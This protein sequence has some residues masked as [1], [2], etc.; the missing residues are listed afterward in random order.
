MKVK[1]LIILALIF[2]LSIPWSA[3][4]ISIKPS[5][6]WDDT[7]DVIP[8]PV[9]VGFDSMTAYGQATG[10]PREQAGFTGTFFSTIDVTPFSGAN[11]WLVEPG[12]TTLSDWVGID[13]LTRVQSG[14]GWNYTIDMRFVSDSTNETPGNIPAPPS[15]PPWDAYPFVTETGSLQNI[16]GAF[17]LNGPF[18]GY[19]APAGFTDLL[20]IQVTSDINEAPPTDGHSTPDGR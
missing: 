3:S 8:A 17:R 11:V 19:T 18:P 13:S 16:T 4:A 7:T 9:G 15:S 20:T 14:S 6:S 12:N 5:I 1:P 10:D 2:C